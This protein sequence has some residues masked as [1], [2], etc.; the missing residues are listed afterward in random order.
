MRRGYWTAATTHFG[1]EYRAA[2][3]VERQGFDYY[4]PLTVNNGRTE[5]LFPNYLFVFIT[6]QW[7]SLLGTRGIRRLIIADEHPV[8]IP[9]W[10]M[11][12]LRA[13]ENT[14]GII[15]LPKPYDVGDKVRITAGVFRDRLAIVQGMPANERISVLLDFLGHKVRTKVEAY[16]I[17]AA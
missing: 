15:E 4:L 9:S 13:R 14:A 7:R 2:H 12:A 17:E 10:E 1:Q 8:R 16:E 3:H 6:K 5:R 11:E